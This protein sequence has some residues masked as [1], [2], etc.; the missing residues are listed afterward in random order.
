G[1][2]GKVTKV[3]DGDCKPFAVKEP[4]DMACLW[5]TW[6]SAPSKRRT[7]PH[8]EDGRPGDQGGRPVLVLEFCSEGGIIGTEY[9]RWMD[10]WSIGALIFF[11]LYESEPGWTGAKCARQDFA[12]SLSRPSSTPTLTLYDSMF[13][14]TSSQRLTFSSEPILST[15]FQQGGFGFIP[16]NVDFSSRSARDDVRHGSCHTSIC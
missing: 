1:E 9:H 6:R 10:I 11:M 13:S 5:S 2:F 7:I 12:K 16:Q 14:F 4:K 8:P 3:L 15:S